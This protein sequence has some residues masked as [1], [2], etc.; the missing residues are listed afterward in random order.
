MFTKYSFKWL[1]DS[2]LL[3]KAVSCQF[4]HIS[5]RISHHKIKLDCINRL[6]GAAHESTGTN[7]IL[8]LQTVAGLTFCGAPCPENLLTSHGSKKC[9]ANCFV[10]FFLDT[11]TK[12]RDSFS[13]TDSLVLLLL[14]HT[15][16]NLSALKL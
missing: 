4:E 5:A 6:P 10:T 2:H 3:A 13:N 9:L 7:Y 1:T 11:I 12:I 14:L 15:N 16:L 8:L